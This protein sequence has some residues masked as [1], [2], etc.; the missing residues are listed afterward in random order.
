MNIKLNSSVIVLLLFFCTIQPVL[1]NTTTSIFIQLLFNFYTTTYLQDQTLMMDEIC[2]NGID[3]DGDGAIDGA[4]LDCQCISDIPPK[5]LISNGQ[6]EEIT[7]CCA[8]LGAPGFNC[9]ENWVIP[10][11]SPDY[12]SDNCPNTDLRPDVDALINKFNTDEVDSYIH[13]LVSKGNSN[14][15]TESF[16]ICFEETLLPGTIYTLSFD[17]ANLRDEVSDDA[18][19]T[20]FGIPNCE[21]LTDYKASSNSA[22]G[23]FC[24]AGLPFERLASL[25]TGVTIQ[26]WQTFTFDITPTTPIEAFFYSADCNNTPQQ[27]FSI[28]LIFDNFKLEEQF[29]GV[30]KNTTLAEVIPSGGSYNFGGQIITSAGI[31][32]DSL[33]TTEGC[34]SIVTLELIIFGGLFENCND[35]F[36]NDGDGLIDAFDE[37]CQC[38]ASTDTMNLVSNGDFE[39]YEI[40]CCTRSVAGE[41]ICVEN[42]THKYSTPDFVH[43]DCIGLA[44]NAEANY[45]DVPL[46]NPFFGILIRHA[47]LVDIPLLNGMDSETIGQCLPEPLIAGETYLISLDVGVKGNLDG[48]QADLTQDIFFTVNGIPD[49]GRLDEYLPEGDF[50]DSPLPYQQLAAVNLFGLNRGWNPQTFEFV[51]D[52]NLDAIF[53]MG[54]CDHEVQ[55]IIIAIA[56]FDNLKIQKKAT[57]QITNEIIVEGNPCDE[58]NMLRFS[59]EQ[60]PGATYQWYLD[61]VPQPNRTTASLTFGLNADIVGTHHVYV[62]FPDGHCEL[63]GP[64][65]FAYEAPSSRDTITICSGSTIL[66]G[67]N[68]VS[69]EGEF[70][71]TFPSIINGCDSTATLVVLIEEV[72]NT[73]ITDTIVEGQSYDFNGTAIRTTGMYRDT[74]LTVRGCDSILILDLLVNFPRGEICDNTIIGDTINI[75]QNLG[76][77]YIFQGFTY[78]ESGVYQVNLTSAAGCDSLVWLNLNLEDPCA[79]LFDVTVEWSDVDC[80]SAENGQIILQTIN[81]AL[82]FQYS[83]DGGNNFSEQTIFNNLSAGTYD[84]VVRDS[85]SCVSTNSVSIA[86]NTTTLFLELSADTFLYEGQSTK[87][88]IIKSNFDP[89]SYDWS[90]DVVVIDCPNCP[91]IRINPVES[92]VYRLTATDE[93]GCQATNTMLVDI[94]PVPQLYIPTAFSPNGDG[95]NDIF[96]I[97]GSPEVVEQV[98]ELKIFN[99][100]GNLVYEQQKSTGRTFLEWD[101]FINNEA[102]TIDV[103]MYLVSWDNPLGEQELL[104]GDFTLIR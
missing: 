19:I 37:D 13:S 35:G 69:V 101:G 57:P 23:H 104:T 15:L 42:W 74:L 38:N 63:I 5:N 39:R 22:T 27:N 66:V 86:T 80:E 26:E 93:N 31:Y 60:I 36:D 88:G 98:T 79:N 29:S 65:D 99:R 40:G 67:G 75:T 56:L 1:A 43:P 73:Y 18:T 46:D 49:C 76:I 77:S 50:C 84:I 44:T 20:F 97:E 96:R 10:G 85:N 47:N 72:N 71:E 4:D 91:T 17:L 11:G 12:I 45:Y 28:N 89:I 14:L 94:R 30:P 82:P 25:Q 8:A 78:N 7:S 102:A 55:G 53:V 58:N 83:I 52:T 54:D 21:D 51:P 32:V 61:A 59:V 41:D 68:I 64:Y 2:N 9:L 92:G 34:D 24:D 62:T 16:G 48:T 90:S 100:W 33:Q 81:G 6:F 3:D 87:L 103:Y 95:N 70:T